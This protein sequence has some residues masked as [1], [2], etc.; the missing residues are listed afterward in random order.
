[1]AD[2]DAPEPASYRK[3]RGR[4]SRRAS[5]GASF[6]LPI[7][8][9][10]RRMVRAAAAILRGRRQ[11]PSTPFPRRQSD[12]QEL[13]G[14]LRSGAAHD[15]P[16]SEMVDRPALH[17][18]DARL[19]CRPGAHACPRR[20]ATQ[21]DGDAGRVWHRYHSA[22]S[23]RRQAGHGTGRHRLDRH[24]VASCT[25]RTAPRT[26]SRRRRSKRSSRARRRC[27]PSP[28][29]G[30]GSTSAAVR[31]FTPSWSRARPQRTASCS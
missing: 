1:M 15:R 3:W 4:R 23:I 10:Q 25:R 29:T 28:S 6:T 5:I 7:F 8:G 13:G 12:R 26:A 24:H 19:D 16:I 22:R 20:P 18:A 17:Q 11:A 2:D 31:K 27:S 14:G 30:F 21:A 9:A